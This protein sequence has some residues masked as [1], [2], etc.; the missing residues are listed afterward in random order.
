MTLQPTDSLTNPRLGDRI[1]Y[2]GLVRKV[3]GRT[4]GFVVYIVEGGNAQFR[5]MTISEWWEWVEK[6]K[7]TLVDRQQ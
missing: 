1:K 2:R 7:P 4:P 5:R 6:A 3:M